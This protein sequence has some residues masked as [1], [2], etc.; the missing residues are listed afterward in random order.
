MATGIYEKPATIFTLLWTNSDPTANFSAKTVSIDLSDYDAV[1][2][3]FFAN[4]NM[5]RQDSVI[6]RKASGGGGLLVTSVEGSGVIR[7]RTAVVSASGVQF[8][9]GYSGTSS[10]AA[11][12]I[13]YKIYGIKG[14]EI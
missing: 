14:L 1:L 10:A 5:T 8:G 9:T 4:A 2:I 12:C 6:I 13:P 11:S 3:Y 7:T